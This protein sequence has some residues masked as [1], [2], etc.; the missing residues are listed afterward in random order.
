V[1]NRFSVFVHIGPKNN[2]ASLLLR[3]PNRR[4]QP[5]VVRWQ[6]EAEAISGIRG[7]PV[8][9][10]S[11]TP[12]FK[13][14]TLGTVFPS[15]FSWNRLIFFEHEEEFDTPQT[16]GMKGRIRD[17]QKFRE[18]VDGGADFARLCGFCLLPK[19]LG[20]RVRHQRVMQKKH[21]YG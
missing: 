3:L 1:L 13:T 12:I 2:T 17:C 5:F 21:R 11:S 14:S 4:I 16:F 9:A 15:R 6:F 10:S 7:S 20:C 18:T 8:Q 19:Y